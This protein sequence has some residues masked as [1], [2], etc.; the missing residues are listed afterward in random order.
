MYGEDGHAG[1]ATAINK[2]RGCGLTGKSCEETQESKR[3]HYKNTGFGC[4]NSTVIYQTETVS[5]T[6]SKN[7][8]DNGT[9]DPV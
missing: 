3:C 5:I 9:G 4:V 1:T 8:I 2:I 7:D 6:G